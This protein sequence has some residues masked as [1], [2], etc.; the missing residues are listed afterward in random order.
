MLVTKATY[1]VFNKNIVISYDKNALLFEL[2]GHLCN[3]IS[4]INSKVVC[5][6]KLKQN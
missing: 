5:L 6:H 4:L 2:H 1:S 3:Y